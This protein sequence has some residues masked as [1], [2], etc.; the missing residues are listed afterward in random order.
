MLNKSILLLNR[1]TLDEEYNSYDECGLFLMIVD[2]I[3]EK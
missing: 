2:P 3:V 1:S